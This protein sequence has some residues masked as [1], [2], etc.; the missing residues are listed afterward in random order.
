MYDT[1]ADKKPFDFASPIEELK[2]GQHKGEKMWTIGLS[3]L[4][5]MGR[6][7]N[8]TDGGKQTIEDAKDM[9]I[10]SGEYAVMRNVKGPIWRCKLQ[11]IYSTKS[12]A[13]THCSVGNGFEDFVYHIKYT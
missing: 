12:I 11:G 9:F 7:L 6:A 4:E 10:R 3:S 2:F 8:L 13:E 5:W 1:T